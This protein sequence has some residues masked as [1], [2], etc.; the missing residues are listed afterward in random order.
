MPSD[1]IKRISN[2]GCHGYNRLK[3][4]AVATIAPPLVDS[5][6][7]NSFSC[8]SGPTVVYCVNVNYEFGCRIQCDSKSR[9]NSTYDRDIKV[10]KLV[11]R[12]GNSEASSETFV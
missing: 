7:Y 11:V 3:R 5:K 4:T 12:G 8:M 6:H 2:Y 10:E 1:I 9:L